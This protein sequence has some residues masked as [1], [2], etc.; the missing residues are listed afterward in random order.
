MNIIVDENTPTEY[1]SSSFICASVIATIY[2][3]GSS[4]PKERLIQLCIEA[5]KLSGLD[6]NGYY[7]INQGFAFNLHLCQKGFVPHG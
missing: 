3:N 7:K 6:T 4:V 2:A 1:D 5:E